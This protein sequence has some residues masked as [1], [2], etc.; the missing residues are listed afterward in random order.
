MSS[1]KSWVLQ[2]LIF[3][4]LSLS[5]SRNSDACVCAKEGK[6]SGCVLGGDLKGCV[7]AGELCA[8]DDTRV[9]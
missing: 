6:N 7:L 3:L 9:R 2:L 8:H 5:S 1:A 4:L